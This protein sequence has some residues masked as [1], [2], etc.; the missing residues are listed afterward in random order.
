MKTANA[1]ARAVRLRLDRQVA[2]PHVPPDVIRD[3]EALRPAHGRKRILTCVADALL[4]LFVGR[5]G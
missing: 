3:N 2:Y 5:H 1:V 4:S